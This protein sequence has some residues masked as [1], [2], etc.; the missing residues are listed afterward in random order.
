MFNQWIGILLAELYGHFVS[1]R[2]PLWIC[3]RR[4][5]NIWKPE[6]RLYCLAVP[7]VILPIGLGLFASAL[8]YH[9]HWVVLALGSILIFAAGMSVVPI[10][11]TYLCEC[12]S[13]FVPE[14]QAIMGFYRLAFSLTTTFFVPPWVA[15]VTVGWV[16]GTGAFLT[17]PAFALF[18]G[19]I[20]FGPKLRKMTFSRLVVEDKVNELTDL[21]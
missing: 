7:A 16:F 15:R 12:F 20:W 13:N 3:H 8:Q 5:D 2:I 19:L 1:D 18:C 17:I 9:L 21:V 6:Y 10:I 14:T 11:M 4:G